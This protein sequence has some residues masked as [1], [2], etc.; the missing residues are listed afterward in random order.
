M[1]LYL[2]M[3]NQQYIDINLNPVI[4]VTAPSPANCNPFP[5][6]V[7]Q[8]MQAYSTGTILSRSFHSIKM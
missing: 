7:K 4:Q 1:K 3:V 2:W 5:N 6:M 8:V